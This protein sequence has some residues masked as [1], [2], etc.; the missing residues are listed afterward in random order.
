M[1]RKLTWRRNTPFLFSAATTAILSFVLLIVLVVLGSEVLKQ[2][3]VEGSLGGPDPGLGLATAGL[4]LF[5]GLLFVAAAATAIA[6]KEEISTSTAVNSA[7]LALAMDNRFHSDRALRIRHGS[8][9]FLA[10][11]Q[12]DSNGD[13]KRQVDLHCYHNI[14]PYGTTQKLWC[15]LTSDLIDLFNYY[16]WMGYLADERTKAIDEE[17]VAQK[18]GPWIINYYQ[19]CKEELAM[20]QEEYP[21]RWHYLKPL[22][23]K[24][25]EREAA[26]YKEERPDNPY[27]GKRSPEQIEDFL[28]R[29]HTR[30]H[31][32]FNPGSHDPLTIPS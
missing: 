11:N 5:T 17:V 27:N 10:S 18:F 29:E 6:A 16:D 9:A 20:V 24:L 19:M 13:L 23:N 4:A 26:R 30:S 28:R 2:I 25:I 3:F 15:G 22:Y 8:V 31:R 7:D 1:A 32:G 14:S 21:G 12:V